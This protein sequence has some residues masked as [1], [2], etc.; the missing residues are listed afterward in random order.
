M[1]RVF[2]EQ[3]DQLCPVVQPGQDLFMQCT[4]VSRIAGAKVRVDLRENGR[5]EIGDRD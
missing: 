2:E 3:S 1:E 4:I 5:K